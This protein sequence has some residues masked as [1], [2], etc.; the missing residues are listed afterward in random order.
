MGIY[1]YEMHFFEK[2]ICWISWLALDVVLGAMAGMLFFS[3]LLHVDLPWPP[4]VLLGLAVWCIYNLDHYLDARKVELQ[5]PRRIF[6]QNTNQ[7]IP[8]FIV[9]FGILGLIGGFWW[10]GWGLELQLTLGLGILIVGIRLVVLKFGRGWMKEFSIA[11]FYVIGISLIPILRAHALDRSMELVLFLGLYLMLALLNL[12]MLSQLDAEE[13]Q[14][15]GFFSAT[16]NISP[17]KLHQWVRNLGFSLLVFQLAL[18]VFLSSYFKIFGLILLLMTLVHVMV[19]M[20]KDLDPVQKRIR[21]EWA[22]VFPWV[23]LLF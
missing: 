14:K 2:S 19:F 1:F 12:L 9:F 8:V 15:A 21:M 16:K 23:L 3:K 6:H 10:L 20:K 5:S 18:F 22:F 7:V 4:F 17:Q 13:D 11:L